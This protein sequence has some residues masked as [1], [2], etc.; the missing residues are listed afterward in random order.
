MNGK[1]LLTELGNISHK[2]YEEAENGTLSSH[3]GAKPHTLRRPL[4]VAALIA[5]MLLL[6]GCAVVYAL[7]LQDMSIGQET[8]TQ[9]FDES[10]KYLEEPVEKTRDILTMYGHSGD[11]IQQALTEWYEFLNTYDPDGK[12]STNDPDLEEIPDQYEYI[13][14]CYTQEMVDKVDEIAEKYGLKLLETRVPFQSYQGHIFLRETGISSLLRPDAEATTSAM[15]GMLYLPENFN[16][17]FDLKMEG[18]TSVYADFAY[19]HRDYFPRD[20]SGGGGLDLSDYEQWDHTAPD[21][22]QLLLARSRKGHGIIIAETET[23]MINISISGNFSGSSYPKE[24]EIISREDLARI[25]DVFDYSIRPQPVDLITVEAALAEA[26]ADY[27]AQNAY[28]PP[29]FADFGDFLQKNYRI[30][31]DNLQ[32]SFYDLTG[33]GEEDLLIGK[34]GMFDMVAYLRDGEVYR[35]GYGET[36]V[37]EDGILEIYSAFEIY[38]THDY[39]IPN[40]NP[41]PDETDLMWEILQILKRTEDQWTVTLPNDFNSAKEITPKEAQSVMDQYPR[42]ELNWKPLV[43]YP[44]ND[45]GKTLGDYQKEQDVRVSDAELKQIYIDYM[46][47]LIDE[48]RMHY[49]HFRILDINGD[50]VDDLLLKGEDDAFIG[51]T[52]YYWIALTYRYGYIEGFA[53][54]FYLCENNVLENVSKRGE[55]GVEI[56]GHQFQRCTNFEIELLEFAA[57]NKATDSWQSDWYDTPMDTTVAEAILAQY[58]RIDQGMRPISELLN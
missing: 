4:L 34:N 25:A 54:D 14:S 15:A 18:M 56:I 55:Y 26:E 16:M 52:D 47:A 30:Y 51:A 48:D 19:T 39:V 38:E 7:R 44:L 43:E 22:R 31:D 10:G 33:D 49:S 2:Y 35:E 17:H 41:A 11:A 6:V 1:D 29:T 20:I 24:D 53:W 28:T 27:Q 5:V 3:R 42:V 21:G 46:K 58:P 23:A 45:A 37:C 50:G 8:Y 57:Y 40:F 13:Y 32:Y 9:T 36:Y 12:Y